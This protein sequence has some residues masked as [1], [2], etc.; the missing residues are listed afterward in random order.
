MHRSC[1]SLAMPMPLRRERAPATSAV[2]DGVSIRRTMNLAAMVCVIACSV[3]PLARAQVPTPVGDLGITLTFPAQFQ[4]VGSASLRE[5]QVAAWRGKLGE[6]SLELS[7]SVPPQPN[8]REPTDVTERA[9]FNLPRDPLEPREE[10]R[11]DSHE[12]I[13]GKFGFVPYASLATRAIRVEGRT[14]VTTLMYYLGGL[15]ETRGY[16]IVVTLSPAPS[17]DEDALLRKFLTQGIGYSGPVRDFRWTDEEA[18]KR[19]KDAVP[20]GDKKPRLLETILRTDHYLI[21]TNSS[22]GKKFGE[23]MEECYAKIREVYPFQDAPGQRLMPVFL[24]QM[25]D[26]YHAFF[27][28]AFDAPLEQA[29]KSKGVAWRDFYATTYEAP[30]D[31]VHIHEATHQIFS[32]RL[33]LWGGGSWFQEGVA[34]YIETSANERNDAAR[35]VREGRHTPLREFVQI[36]SLLFSP[37]TEDAD[38]RGGGSAGDHYKQAALIIEFA[39]ESKFGKPRFLDWLHAIGDV[40][41]NDLEAIEAATRS[42]Y[43]VDLAGFEKEFVAY[44]KKR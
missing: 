21:L 27:V 15:L 18:R 32:N 8:F 9:R 19:W 44:C 13:P 35:L 14:D 31:P 5:H 39:R 20:D 38:P 28:K 25:P 37:K 41:R 30:K 16:L 43:G 12:L 34:E 1:P 23:K 36:E 6:K 33:H 22:G 26:E 3:L 42:V 11:W 40:A 17:K 7:V 24:F 10:P 4:L 29:R 2:D